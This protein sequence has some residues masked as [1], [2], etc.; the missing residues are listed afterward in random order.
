[1]NDLLTAAVFEG[2]SGGNLFVAQVGVC[3]SFV[4]VGNGD[5]EWGGGWWLMGKSKG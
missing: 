1:M 2:M 3:L 4:V 5:R